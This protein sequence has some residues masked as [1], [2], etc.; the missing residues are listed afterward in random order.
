M[1]PSALRGSF[2]PHF[3]HRQKRPPQPGIRSMSPWQSGHT[4]SFCMVFP[5]LWLRLHF[6]VT[7]TLPTPVISATTRS[8]LLICPTPAGVPVRIRSPGSRVK[9]EER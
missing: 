6:T 3:W 2:L 9:M 1:E 8:P 5:S 4:F 7:L